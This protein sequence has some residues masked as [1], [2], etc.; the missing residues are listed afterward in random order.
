M[1]EYQFS[2]DSAVLHLHNAEKTSYF[3]NLGQGLLTCLKRTFENNFIAEKCLIFT[4]KARS[5]SLVVE[6][7]GSV[8]MFN[9]WRWF[10]LF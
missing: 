10:S 4:R 6:L 2:S 1:G 8:A 7:F 5:C 3:Q 9:I